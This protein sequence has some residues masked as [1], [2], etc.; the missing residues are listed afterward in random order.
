MRN[1]A[2]A[3]E[4]TKW[5]TA[6]FIPCPPKDDDQYHYHDRQQVVKVEFKRR[7]NPLEAHELIDQNHSLFIGKFL[8][9][10]ARQKHDDVG[11]RM[12]YIEKHLEPPLI[13]SN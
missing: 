12:Q 10:E 11:D 3:F 9:C 6:G 13:S 7:V 8:D 1:H 2:R 4:S 5:P